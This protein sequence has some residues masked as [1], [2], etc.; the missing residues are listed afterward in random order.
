M[1]WVLKFKGPVWDALIALSLVVISFAVFAL[2]LGVSL[3]S[4]PVEEF[5]FRLRG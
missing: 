1:L 4:G 3:R 5:L 2:V